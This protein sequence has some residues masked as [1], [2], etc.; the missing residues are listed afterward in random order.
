MQRLLIVVLSLISIQ[1]Y[2]QDSKVKTQDIAPPP[3]S[4]TDYQRLTGSDILIPTTE[5]YS[6]VEPPTKIHLNDSDIIL[7]YSQNDEAYVQTEVDTY[8]NTQSVTDSTI[9]RYEKMEA[10][11]YSGRSSNNSTASKLY[12]TTIENIGYMITIDYTATD[13]NETYVQDLL[14]AIIIDHEHKIPYGDHIGFN[15]NIPNQY[16]FA[17]FRFMGM[18]TIVPNGGIPMNGSTLMFLS[19]TGADDKDKIEMQRMLS[20]TLEMAIITPRDDGRLIMTKTEPIKPGLD[21]HQFIL[22][23]GTH[24]FMGYLICDSAD[25]MQV[26]SQMISSISSK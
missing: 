19:M 13:D 14:S 11:I 6:L 4:T 21:T 8:L 16:E 20:S 2:A 24:L 5:P 25:D 10:S 12:Y 22:E 7:S 3:E 15:I 26:L 23:V 18:H 1:L 17:D 9:V